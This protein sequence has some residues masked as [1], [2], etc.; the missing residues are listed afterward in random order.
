VPPLGGLAAFGE[1][2][3]VNQEHTPFWS[4]AA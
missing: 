2:Q 3:I 1:S 4:S